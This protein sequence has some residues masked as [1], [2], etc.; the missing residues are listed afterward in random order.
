MC[1]RDRLAVAH[2]FRL[3]ITQTLHLV[4]FVFRIGSFKEKDLTVSFE[5]QDMGTDTVQEPTVVADHHR[6]AREGRI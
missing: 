2:P 3:L 5:S 6:T 1:I 4:L